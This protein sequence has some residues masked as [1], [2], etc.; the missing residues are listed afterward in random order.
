MNSASQVHSL[1]GD[2][3]QLLLH[4]ILIIFLLYVVGNGEDELCSACVFRVE[5][6]VSSQCPCDEA[7]HVESQSESWTVVV[8][9]LEMFED[10]LRLLWWHACACVGHHELQ[11][12]SIYIMCHVKG[13]CAAGGVL[14]G[15]GDEVVE[16]LTDALLV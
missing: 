7:A 4:D 2:F 16:H 13:D 6:D 3:L 11:F 10:D 9:F 15:I 8:D 14:A 12:L 1:C 5:V